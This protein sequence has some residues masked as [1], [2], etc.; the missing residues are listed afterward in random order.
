MNTKKKKKQEMCGYVE[1][2]NWLKK[3]KFIFSPS[4]SSCAF[5]D[6]FFFFL[7]IGLFHSFAVNLLIY[8]KEF[9]FYDFF[10][11]SFLNVFLVK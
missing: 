1:H 8:P 7:V 11:M 10:R 3:N 5:A 6:F 9:Y 2:R 4:F